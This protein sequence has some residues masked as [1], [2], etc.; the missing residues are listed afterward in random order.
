MILNRD[1]NPIITGD[2]LNEIKKIKNF[3]DYKERNEYI[4]YLKREVGYL[5]IVL[6]NFYDSKEFDFPTFMTIENQTLLDN[7][8]NILI[9]SE[10]YKNKSNWSMDM[11]PFYETNENPEIRYED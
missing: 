6:N 10:D 3:T 8:L 9:E 2:I 7:H 1:F 4:N 11:K 5:R